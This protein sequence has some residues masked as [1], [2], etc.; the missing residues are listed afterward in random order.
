MVSI[1]S[2]RRKRIRSQLRTCALYVPTILGLR[3]SAKP[4]AATSDPTVSGI[5]AP[6]R[7]TRPPDQRESTNISRMSGSRAAPAA[8]GSEN[9]VSTRDGRNIR[10][11][12]DGV[13]A[14]RLKGNW[15]VDLLALRPVLD[16]PGYFD[17][18]P[19]HSSS[20]W[21]AYAV[22]PLRVLPGGGVD[23]YYMGLDNGACLSMVKGPALNNERQSAHACGERP[24][25]LH[26][27]T[28]SRVQIT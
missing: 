18:P 4:D 19:D 28:S 26:G 12:L 13:R 8:L 6:Y 7:A 24:N 1:V 2:D 11:S 5:L 23:L 27:E 3:K 10:N 15:K 9:L 25:S 16:N 21:A 22:G 20:F 17:N 14:T